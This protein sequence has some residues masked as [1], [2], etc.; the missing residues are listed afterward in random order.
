M[1][2]WHR[3]AWWLN[4]MCLLYSVPQ[5]GLGLSVKE[6]PGAGEEPAAAA[7]QQPE[8]AASG[9]APTAAAAAS[10]GPEP[11]QQDGAQPPAAAEPEPERSEE[12]WEMLNKWV[13]LRPR[14]G[15]CRR[16]RCWCRRR[17]GRC[18][19]RCCP[20]S[21]R[22]CLRLVAAHAPAAGQPPPHPCSQPWQR[23]T[24]GPLPLPP[25]LPPGRRR[26]CR[27]RSWATRR[28]R[29]SSLMP[30]SSTTTG[31]G[32]LFGVSSLSLLRG[33]V[34]WAAAAAAPR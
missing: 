31:E 27:R 2:G 6:G 3:A 29:R 15:T 14:L 9:A 12:E 26:R 17:H 25:P 20:C 10:S 30:P 24:Y 32:L 34:S 22:L 21:G 5:V 18:C 11:M 33:A 1:R 7:E 16:C 23:A 13:G 28:T 4:Q 19:R 8:A